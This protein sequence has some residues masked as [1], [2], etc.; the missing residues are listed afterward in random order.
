MNLILLT[1][2]LGGS[3]TEHE[4]SSFTYDAAQQ[5]LVYTEGGVLHTQS[6]I[7]VFTYNGTMLTC[8][9]DTIFANAFD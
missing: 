7:V 9:T 5:L 3:L 4:V 6:G 8:A 2:I 1:L